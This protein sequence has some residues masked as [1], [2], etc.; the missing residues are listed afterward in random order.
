MSR[1][2]RWIRGIAGMGW[3]GRRSFSQFGEDLFVARFF[4]DHAPG[5][6]LDVGAFHPRVAS[7]TLALRRRGWSGMN[8]DADPEKM[9][10]FRLVRPRDTNITA[11][12]AGPDA[13][14]AV[15]E[16]VG[17]DSYGSMDRLCMLAD[18]S[19][20]A[21]RSIADL[22]S[23]NGITTVGFVSMDVEGLE[24]EILRGFPFDRAEV[25]LFC[26]EVLSWTLDE[27]RASPVTRILGDNGYQ[28]VGWTPPSVFFARSPRPGCTG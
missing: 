6:W 11:A 23:D 15:L 7:N 3:R 14:F 9:R 20:V 13:G 28:I 12:V 25:E 22:L 5:V 27:V 4:E 21:T 17:P 2:P 24:S 1:V 18:G 8:V 19:G 26:I 10:L 16:R